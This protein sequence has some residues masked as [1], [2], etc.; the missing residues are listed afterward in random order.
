M[1]LV[2][3]LLDTT[4]LQV[5]GVACPWEWAD[6]SN[7]S[8]H[9]HLIPKNHS[10][11]QLQTRSHTPQTMTM[12]LG[13]HGGDAFERSTQIDRKMLHQRYCHRAA[14]TRIM[15]AFAYYLKE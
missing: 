14:A 2:D 9:Y 1:R 8:A 4:D 3:E 6:S 10:P 12:L 5:D 15:V 13:V 7:E 11:V